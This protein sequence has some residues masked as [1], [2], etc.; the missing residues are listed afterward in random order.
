M[1]IKTLILIGLIVGAILLL[2]AGVKFS[3]TNDGELNQYET[4]EQVEVVEEVDSF[5]DDFNQTLE[6][7][8]QM[9]DMMTTIIPLIIG[10]ILLGVITSVLFRIFFRDAGIGY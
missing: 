2:I 10:M 7:Q 8:L 3:G 5:S 1:K 6:V 9:A 4:Y